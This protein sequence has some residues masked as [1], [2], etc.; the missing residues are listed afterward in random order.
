MDNSHSAHPNHPLAASTLIIEKRLSNTLAQSSKDTVH[1]STPTFQSLPSD[2]A[3][4]TVPKS[5]I[6]QPEYYRT[7]CGRRYPGEALEV[8]V[9]WSVQ[10]RND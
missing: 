2:S 7:R 9:L 3:N 1:P 4:P 6:S 10:R 8:G 5:S